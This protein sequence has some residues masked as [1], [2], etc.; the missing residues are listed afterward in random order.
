MRELNLQNFSENKDSYVN[1]LTPD[2]STNTEY[3]SI[4]NFVYLPNV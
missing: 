1:R 4:L 2:N 3:F